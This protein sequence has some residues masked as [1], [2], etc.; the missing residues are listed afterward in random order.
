MVEL[1]IK[2]GDSGNEISFRVEEFS[3][4]RTIYELENCCDLLIHLKENHGHRINDDE[5]YDVAKLVKV[6]L[7]GSNINWINT[8]LYV[9]GIKFYQVL[10]ANRNSE[11]TE[12]DIFDDIEQVVENENQTE[13]NKTLSQIRDKVSKSLYLKGII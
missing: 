11:N 9:E 12:I 8:F 7:S 2:I 10:E 4:T 5:L 1:L 3:S 6:N 13:V